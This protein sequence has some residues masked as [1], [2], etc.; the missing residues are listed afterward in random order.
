M[1]KI[2]WTD[3]TW[4]PITGCTKISPGCKNCY[5]ERM[6]ERLK[7]RFGYPLDDP[8]RPGTFHPEQI[9]KPYNWKNRRMIFVCSMGDLFHEKVSDSKLGVIFK[10]M[11]DNP[12]HTFLLLTKRPERM[13][14]YMTE[15][16][17][18][19]YG[20]QD[21]IW[22][23]VTAENQEQ[24]DKRIP[25][26]LETPAAVRFVSVEPM[27]G[28]VDI[29]IYLDSLPAVVD[30]RPKLD[31]VICGCESGPGAREMKMEWALNLKDQCVAASVPFFL[32]QIAVCDQLIKMPEING[33]VWDQMPGGE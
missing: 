30:Q 6:A 15:Y 20:V 25:I 22:L 16:Q 12:K 24:A 5:A 9:M 11:R 32:K 18:F 19:N 8:F 1:S 27:L 10:I 7:G 33:K 23:G 3:E 28:P 13:H 31:W 2:Q 4:N 21:N 14:E 29:S 17:I 26:L